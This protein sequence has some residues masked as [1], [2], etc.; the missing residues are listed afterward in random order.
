MRLCDPRPLQ[1]HPGLPSLP[2]DY[3]FRTC[4]YRSSDMDT[5]LTMEDTGFLSTCFRVL[6]SGLAALRNEITSVAEAGDHKG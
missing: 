1:G 2:L 6:C 3:S 5:N 4:S